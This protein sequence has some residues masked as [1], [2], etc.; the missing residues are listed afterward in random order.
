MKSVQILL[1]TYNGELYIREQVDSLLAQ[2]YRDIQILIRDDGSTDQTRT[3]L[4][5][6]SQYQNIDVRFEGN[7]GV[8]PSFFRL[9]E[10]ASDDAGY[11]AFCDQDDY[12]HANKIEIAIQRL[13][14][15]DSAIPAMYCGRV[16]LVNEDLQHIGLYPL[17]KRGPSFENAIVQNIATGCTIVMNQAARNLILRHLPDMNKVVMHDWW[18]YLVV[19]AFGVVI[20]DPNPTMLYRQ[21]TNNTMG[22]SHNLLTKWIV[23]LRRYIKNGEYK[24]ITDQS[25]EFYHKYQDFLADEKK[26]VLKRF[27]QSRQ[28]VF[29]RIGYFFSSDV[30]RQSIGEDIAC[31]VLLLFNLA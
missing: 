11:V 12:W 6:Y 25:L 27:L 15:I 13:E 10:E 20:Y 5:Q 14:K 17:H 18:F 7:I 30:Y 9:L 1:S 24:F 2:T 21:H 4:E 26:V 31:R 3:I 16:E 8:I 19:S 28:S 22:T 23:R 29:H